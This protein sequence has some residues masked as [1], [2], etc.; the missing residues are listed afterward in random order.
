MINRELYLA[1]IRPFMNKPFVKVITGVRRSGKS[2]I[3]RMV[4]D[5]LEKMTVKPEDIIYINFDSMK[6]SGIENGADLYT[7]V[8]KRI[9]Q[10]EKSYLMFDEI[11]EVINWEKAINSFLVD[12]DVDIYITGSNSRL[13]SS[14][15]STYIAGRYVEFTV[16]PLSFAETFDFLTGYKIEQTTTSIDEYFDHFAKI[17]GF[18]VLYTSNYD[19]DS[20]LKIV[21][22]IYSSVILRDI[23]S[24]HNIRNIALLE[25]IIK[26]IFDNIGNTFS[27]KAMSDYFKNE[28]R[29][30]NIE[31]IY[32]YL[33]Y[34]EDAFIVYRVSRYDLRGKEILKT[35]EKFYLS[36]QAFKN[37]IIGIKGY[38]ISGILENI[39]YLELKRRDYTVYIGKLDDR[40]IDFVAERKGKKIYVQ[41]AYRLSDEKTIDREFGN[42]LE[43]LDNHP[44]YVVSTEKIFSDNIKGVKHV[45]IVEFL[46]MKEY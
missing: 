30:V 4:K 15:L 38:A 39:I 32:N 45:N 25:K 23:V 1:K 20:A 37:A 41:V 13:L 28:K 36:D 26:F 19:E 24:R 43:I 12:F 17:G 29:T 16:Y 40:E 27:A 7:H 42:L 46:L 14:E 11:Q 31:T 8:S 5:E 6:N 2:A 44:K 21:S 35:S 9:I 34:L 10:N 22:D 3:L 33:S 18:P